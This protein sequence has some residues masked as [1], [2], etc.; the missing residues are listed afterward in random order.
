MKSWEMPCSGGKAEREKT[1]FEGYSSH[2]PGTGQAKKNLEN[3][4][5]E[6]EGK[7]VRGW[8]D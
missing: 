6:N 3:A 8:S 5:S 4:P 1:G 7:P 2:P